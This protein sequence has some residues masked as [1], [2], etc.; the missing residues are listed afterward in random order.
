MQLETKDYGVGITI[1]TSSNINR[2][3]TML[4]T[5]Q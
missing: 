4:R 5:E 1:T 3:V 2:S